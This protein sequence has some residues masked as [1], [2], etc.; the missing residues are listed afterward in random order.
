MLLTTSPLLSA[1]AD[2]PVPFT[3]YTFPIPVP[4]MVTQL[5]YDHAPVTMVHNK[6]PPNLVVYDNNNIPFA[7]KY[8]TWAECSKDSSSLLHS[9]S[10]GEA[11]RQRLESSEVLLMC[12]IVD[13][14]CWLTP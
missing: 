12:L 5:R 10:A 13:A 9:M 8:A 6:S 11:G 14:C 3:P 2:G 4:W 1:P 7:H